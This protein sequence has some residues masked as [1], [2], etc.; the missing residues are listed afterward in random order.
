MS[1][2]MVQRRADTGIADAV[3]AE[4]PAAAQLD[5]D[6]RHMLQIL[7]AMG[8]KPVGELRAPEARALPTLDMALRRLLRDNG[9]SHGIDMEMRLIPGPTGDIRARI[10]SPA[11]AG[12]ESRPLILYFH[13]GGFVLGDLDQYDAT[14]R[15]LAQRT[16]AIVV[17]SHYRQAPESRFPAAHEDAWAA[18]TWMIETAKSLGG[19]SSRAAIVGEGS[20][21]NLALNVA[22]R[23]RDSGFTTPAHVGLVTPMAAMLF[24]LPS[25]LENTETLPLNTEGL[26]W[27]ARKL[28]RDKEQMR[29][30]RM[31]LAGRSDLAGLPPVTVILAEADPLRSEGEALADALRRAGVVTD[32]TVYDGVTH[33]FFGLAQVVNKAMFAQS[34]LCGNL[35]ASFAR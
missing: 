5:S 7:E 21:G 12:S 4:A 13:G 35:A 6:M 10:Y 17:S 30:G 28:F 24:D 18:W 1:S 9:D 3:V 34:Q 22:I 32:V 11:A 19:D 16:G 29:D 2:M 14:P 20:G 25:H 15:S 33:G 8:G 31:N 23:A 27:A 26:K